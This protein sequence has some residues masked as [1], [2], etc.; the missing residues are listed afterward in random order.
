[1]KIEKLNATNTSDWLDFFDNRAFSDHPDWKGCYCTF[2]FQPK[3]EQF[4]ARRAKKRD[5]AVW[6]I[7][8]GIMRGYLAYEGPRVIGWCNANDRAQFG[9]LAPLAEAD[10]GKIKSIV[11]FLVEKEYRLKGVATA[12]LERVIRDAQAEGFAVLEAYPQKESLSEYRNYHGSYSM[13]ARHGFAEVE[14]PGILIMR[15]S[16]Q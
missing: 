5:Y 1:M 10:K 9:R 3:P 15:K 14:A 13:Y 4:G 12:L 16:L 11:C 7:E 2:Y 8:Q 6:L